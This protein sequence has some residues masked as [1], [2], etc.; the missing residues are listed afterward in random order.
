MINQKQYLELLNTTPENRRSFFA[1]DFFA[2]WFYYYTENFV[3]PLAP[4]HL[5][6]IHTLENTDLNI[7]I[8]GFRWSIKTSV[9]VAFITWCICYKKHNFIVWQSFWSD[10]SQRMTKQIAMNLMDSRLMFDYW[11]LFH[12]NWSREDMEKKSIGDFDT[13][14][15][16][17]ILAASL[18]EKLRGAIS[19]NSR[20]DLL[21]LD[22][23]DVTDS[24]RNSEIIQKNYDKITG[25]TI[26]A[27][28]KD[29]S[30]IIF[31][32]NVINADGVVPRFENEK[33]NDPNWKIFVQPLYNADGS[34]AWDFFT[35]EKIEKIL[36]NEWKRAFAQNYLLQPIVNGNL[37]FT[38]RD[39]LITPNYKEDDLF[40]ELRLYREPRGGLMIGVD[41]SGGGTWWDLS[42]ISVRDNEWKLYAFYNG[43]VP[44]D[45]LHDQIITRIFTLGYKWRLAIEV[46]NT[47]IA[48]INKAKEWKFKHY[49]Y[50]ER[51]VDER[52]NRV[53]KK[54]GWNTTSKTRPLM[55]SELEEA[56]RNWV[57]VEVDERQKKEMEVFAYNDNF[58]PEAMLPHHDDCIIAD[59]ICWQMRKFPYLTF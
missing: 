51:T 8:K 59:S 17:K 16:V 48:T 13:K 11:V 40:P 23:I 54:L 41:T 1:W 42:A 10:S 52:T 26:G 29:R 46:N 31:L 36:S 33:A 37:F 30:R 58:K 3:A 2:W 57:I 4:F 47:G 56:V 7:L 19:R 25:E 9:I 45:E 24:V 34:V 32:G 14:N 55:L 50:S 20:P 22:D 15:G 6:W 44:P 39:N 38:K 18:W 35:K 12:P 28:S 27:M 5:D 53:S 43:S 49:L 21:I